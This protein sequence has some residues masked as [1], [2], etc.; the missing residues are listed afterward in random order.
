MTWYRIRR[1]SKRQSSV[2]KHYLNHKELTRKLVMS[3]LE[4]FN[5]Y[6]NFTYNRV[7]IRNQKRC[8]G[9][10]TSLKNL[11]FS[12]RLLFLPPELCDYVIVHELCHLAELNHS[13]NFWALVAKTIPDY[14]E[15]I[16]A[17]KAHEHLAIKNLKY[18]RDY[19]S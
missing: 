7:A 13:A 12:Y 15:K 4:Y 9:S 18:E 8:W 10:C 19:I 2:T 5:Q 16:S 11:N 17:L 3:R 1:R 6:Y 14:Q